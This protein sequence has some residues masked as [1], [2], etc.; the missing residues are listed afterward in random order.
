MASRVQKWPHGRQQ[1]S[2]GGAGR[3]AAG[4]AAPSQPALREAALQALPAGRRMHARDRGRTQAAR[5]G[6][7]LQG[8]CTEAMHRLPRPHPDSSARSAAGER[9]G[10][11]GE[12][13]PVTRPM[14]PM[15]CQAH[16]AAQL[17]TCRWRGSGAHR[18][19]GTSHP[20]EQAAGKTR[21]NKKPPACPIEPAGHQQAAPPHLVQSS[22][23]HPA[24]TGGAG[25]GMA[26][27]RQL[28]AGILRCSGGGRHR[29]RCGEGGGRAAASPCSLP[30]PAA[31][32]APKQQ[33]VASTPQAAAVECLGGIWPDMMIQA[34]GWPASHV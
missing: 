18:C 14:F 26:G 17:C 32:P 9:Q 29:G 16:D 20:T 21:N 11:A 15:P 1:E 8:P 28:D 5:R 30:H 6:H 19:S 7:A 33:P 24:S 4:A 31:S 3:A 10:E 25:A 27:V 23:Q 2:L 22:L 13:Q 34:Q 12:K